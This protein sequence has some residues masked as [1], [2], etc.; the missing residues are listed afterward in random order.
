MLVE[1][2]VEWVLRS[3]LRVFVRCVL[4]VWISAGRV[5]REEV[6]SV[7]DVLARDEMGGGETG[8]AIRQRWS[9]MVVSWVDKAEAMG[10]MF[11]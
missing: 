6:C 4:V 5:S 11:E 10:T 2:R 1:R 8:E 9:A 3:V 7:S